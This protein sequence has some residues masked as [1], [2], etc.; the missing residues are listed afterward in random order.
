[1]VG[2]GRTDGRPRSARPR[3]VCGMAFRRRRRMGLAPQRTGGSSAQAGCSRR[4]ATGTA[5]VGMVSAGGAQRREGGGG[6]ARRCR[7]R[8][9]PWAAVASQTHRDDPRLDALCHRLRKR[10]YGQS[11]QLRERHARHV[12]VRRRCGSPSESGNRCCA[13]RC[14]SCTER[15]RGGDSAQPG[16]ENRGGQTGSGFGVWCRIAVPLLLLLAR[17]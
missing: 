7:G 13:Q 11:R 5:S 15:P 1:M 14:T 10:F 2:Q 12:C 9:C 17:A 4:A 16:R 8:P 3:V 6:S